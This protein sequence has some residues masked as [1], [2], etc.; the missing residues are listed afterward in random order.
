MSV[1]WPQNDN[2]SEAVDRVIRGRDRIRTAARP[3]YYE[4]LTD[5]KG[6]VH[7]TERDWLSETVERFGRALRPTN[8]W[9]STWIMCLSFALDLAIIGGVDVVRWLITGVWK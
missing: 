3:K 6:F 5:K 2:P 7:A 4:Y 9:S 8:P 1:E